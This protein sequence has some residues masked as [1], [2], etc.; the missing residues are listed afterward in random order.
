[1]DPRGHCDSVAPHGTKDIIV[2]LLGPMVPRAQCEAA[3]LCGTKSPLLH[4]G[5]LC[6]QKAVV[7]LQGTVDPWRPL[8]HCKAP[9][10]SSQPG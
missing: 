3:E 10:C 7:I 6:S 1:M 5:A 4:Y 8:W 2:A 9:A